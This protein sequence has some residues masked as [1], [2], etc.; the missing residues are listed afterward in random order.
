MRFPVVRPKQIDSRSRITLFGPEFEVSI[1]ILGSASPVR[2]WS[3][4]FGLAAIFTVG[5]FVY[6]P[7]SPTGG[8]RW[9]EA[10]RT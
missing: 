10:H 3:I 4:L 8:C 6:S 5:C 7:F 9:R 1:T 2:Y